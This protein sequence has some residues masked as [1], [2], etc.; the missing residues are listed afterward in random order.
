MVNSTLDSNNARK[1]LVALRTKIN[2]LQEHL[3]DITLSEDDAEAL[4]QCESER[5]QGL[6]LTDEQVGIALGE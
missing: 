6:L 5:E 1:Q 2:S 4:R 3:D